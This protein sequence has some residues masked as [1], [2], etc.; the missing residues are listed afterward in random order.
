M[1]IPTLTPDAITVF[2]AGE[3]FGVYK[4]SAC[5]HKVRG[6][7]FFS[8]DKAIAFAQQE[9]LRTHD[10]IEIDSHLGPVALSPYVA[11]ITRLVVR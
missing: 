9:A 6:T 2:P 11:A 5:D 3:M 10:P 1:K 7:T 8:F 4:L